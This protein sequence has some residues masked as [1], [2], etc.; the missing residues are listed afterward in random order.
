MYEHAHRGFEKSV[1]GFAGETLAQRLVCQE[2]PGKGMRRQS[3][4]YRLVSEG[5]L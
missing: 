2:N 5:P 4:G 1:R 3:G